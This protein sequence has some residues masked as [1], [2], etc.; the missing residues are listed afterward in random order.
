M[1]QD[2]S[3]VKL[4]QHDKDN[5]SFLDR[6]IKL[7]RKTYQCF[8]EQESQDLRLAAQIFDACAEIRD[9]LN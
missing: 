2:E 9:S 4:T 8:D 7:A 6:L 1:S 3:D 5:N